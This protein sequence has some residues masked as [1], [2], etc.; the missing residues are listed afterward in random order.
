MKFQLKLISCTANPTDTVLRAARYLSASDQIL[1]DVIHDDPKLLGCV[2]ALFYAEIGMIESRLLPG[3]VL[4]ATDM[5]RTGFA[6]RGEYEIPTSLDGKITP[7]PDGHGQSVSAEG[8]YH[9]TMQLIQDSYQALIDTG[10]PIADAGKLLPIGMTQRILW[11]VSLYDLFEMYRSES[12]KVLAGR[13]LTEISANVDPLL[14][15]LVCKE[16]E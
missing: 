12:W 10:V 7:M 8:L 1:S 15:P 9:E 13:A 6:D 2:Q 5:S 4:R 14:F 16:S 11:M 3:S